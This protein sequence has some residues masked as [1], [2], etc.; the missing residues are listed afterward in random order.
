VTTK[1]ANLGRLPI[2]VVENLDPC[3]DGGRYAIKRVIGQELKVSADIFK[4]DNDQISANLKWRKVTSADWNQTPMRPTE[5]DRWEGVCL[6]VENA[7]HE[8]TIEAWEDHFKSWQVE[9]SKKYG[10]GNT[11][12][13]NELDVAS[14]LVQRAAERATRNQDKERLALF[15]KQLKNADAHFGAQLAKNSELTELMAA[16]PDLELS[17]ELQPYLPVTVDRSEALFA[18]WYEFFPRSAEGKPNA[19]SK[20]RDCLGRIDDAKA[21]GFDVIYF[22]PIHPI[23]FTN[24]KGK[25]NSVTSEPSDPGVPYAIGSQFGG[26]KA[27]EPELGTLDDFDWLVGQVRA[28]GMEIA[29]DFAINCSPDHPYVKEHP[30][31]FFHLPDGSIQCAENPPKKYEDVYPLNFYNSDWKNLWEEMKDIILFWIHHGVRIFRV[32]NPHTKPNAFWEWMIS[33]IQT[34]YPDVIFLAEAFTRPKLMKALAKAGFTQSYTYFTWRNAKWELSEY[35][36]ELTQTEMKYYFRANFF[37]NTPDILPFFL[38]TGGRPAFMIRAVLAATLS[39]VYGIY[40][41]FE[42]CENMAIPG[43]EEYLNSEK[44]Q[45]KER[46]WNAPGNIKDYITKLNKIRHHNRALREY[47]NLRFHMVENEQI[48]FYSKATEALDNVILVLVTLDPYNS[49]SGHACVPIENFG[50]GASDPYQVEDLIT[51]ENFTW[52]GSRNFVILDP[53]SRPAHVFRVRSA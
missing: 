17:T 52:R 27:V 35:L 49:Q 28:R 33:G 31:W 19:G 2:V 37:P 32:D 51:G 38:Q 16:W 13:R 23:G 47:E 21:M 29:L 46:D 11:N 42:L 26:H 48:L 7:L 24:R 18:A 14:I 22:P 3:I 9:Y 10:A 44:Y 25:N 53:H 30:D 6:F 1:K 41:G 39:S 40:S 50:I 34:D 4:Q 15:S 5:N 12:L 20:F 36:T 45:F 43:K 8:F